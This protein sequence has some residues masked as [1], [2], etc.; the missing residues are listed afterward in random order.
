V[1]GLDWTVFDPDLLARNIA[2]RDRPEGLH[3]PDNCGPCE[4]CVEF[5]RRPPELPGAKPPTAEQLHRHA[6]RFGS[7][8]I[9]ETA[10]EYGVDLRLRKRADA[11]KRQRRT[12][13]GLEQEFAQLY[14]ERRMVLSAVA[15]VLNISDRRAATLLKRLEAAGWHRNDVVTAGQFSKPQEIPLNHAASAGEK[16]AG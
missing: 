2:A 8:L 10:R 4:D 6:E 5:L 11:P 13:A 9:A 3:H 15:D 12:S 16:G 7:E 14:F 1:S